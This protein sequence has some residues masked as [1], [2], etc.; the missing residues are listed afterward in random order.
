M[1]GRNPAAICPHTTAM[2]E[3]GVNA[4]CMVVL[5]IRPRVYSHPGV[6]A[7]HSLLYL[8]CLL[9]GYLDFISL[10]MSVVFVILDMKVYLFGGGHKTAKLIP[11]G[12]CG[13]SGVGLVTL[14]MRSCGDCPNVRNWLRSA[15]CT[16]WQR[17]IALQLS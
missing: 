5:G 6:L 13:I 16:C 9:A 15:S 1:F 3:V 10:W 14:H 17:R 7:Q 2:K 11:Q 4:C 12:V 8:G